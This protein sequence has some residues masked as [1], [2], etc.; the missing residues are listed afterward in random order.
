[1]AGT[2]SP[3]LSPPRRGRWAGGAIGAQTPSSPPARWSARAGPKNHP[4]WRHGHVPGA[5]RIRR[6]RRGDPRSASADSGPPVRGCEMQSHG[7]GGAVL[8][9][10]IISAGGVLVPA[11]AFM[12]ALRKAADDRGM[13]LIFDEAQTAFARIGRKTGAEYFGVVPD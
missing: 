11:R 6:P 8:A 9:E 1:M 7:L 4:S 3:T 10:P 2:S 13:L 5:K 12:Q